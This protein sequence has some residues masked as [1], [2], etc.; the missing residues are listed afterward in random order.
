MAGDRETCLRAGMDDY[1]SKP[2]DP[3]LLL[4]TVGRWLGGSGRPRDRAEP[5]SAQADPAV[6]PD[7]DSTHLDALAATVG[8]ATLARLLDDYL[9]GEPERIAQ[10]ENLAASADLDGLARAA[11]D[12]IG[13]AGNFGAR[14]LHRVAQRL[15][16]ACLAGDDGEIIGA[17]VGEIRQA[18]RIAHDA[19]A[20]RVANA[21]K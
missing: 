21:P 13:V 12:L 6:N 7:L 1:I 8:D 20:G 14:R 11:H 2:F 19:I 3:P 9:A 16:R 18:S 10:I 5:S 15:E 4:A 17:L